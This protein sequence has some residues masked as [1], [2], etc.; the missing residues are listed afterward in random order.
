MNL[1]KAILLSSVGRKYIMAITGAAMAAF[2]FVHLL[3]NLQLFL[4]ADA[5]N[6]YAVLLHSNVIILWGYR[7]AMTGIALVH[8]VVALSLWL[9]NR[10][11]RPVAYAV[12]S[13]PYTD[14]AA[15]MMVCG[16]VAIFFFVIWHLVDLTAGLTRPEVVNQYCDLNGEQVKDVFHIVI[17][18]IGHP[19]AAL[20]YI[21]G[22]CC[23][24]LHLWHGLESVFQSL[25]LRNETYKLYIRWITRLAV[26]FLFC[27]MCLIPIASVILRHMGK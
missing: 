9:E 17:N 12:K 25:G 19:V 6:K 13:L 7:F 4:G 10:A 20:C 22:T 2:V 18:G 8:I 11:A 27:G 15:R 26:A 24:A 1:I 23:L 5:I 21:I 14:F 16:G 3:G